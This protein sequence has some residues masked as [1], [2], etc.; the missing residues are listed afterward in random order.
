MYVGEIASAKLRGVFG[1]FPQLLL[2]LGSLVLYSLSAISGFHYHSIALVAVGIVA[3][4]ELGMVWLPETPRWLFSQ[5]MKD[6]GKQVLQ[7]LR[8]PKVSVSA[9]LSELEEAICAEKPSVSEVLREFTK[10]RLFFPFVLVLVIMFFQQISGMNAIGAYIVLLFQDAGISNPQLATVYVAII[11]FVSTL[12]SSYIVDVGGRKVL[13]TISGIGMAIGTAMLGVHFYITRPSLCSDHGEN[14]TL[15]ESLQDSS[16]TDTQCNKQYSPLAI[17]SVIVF[18]I[19]MALGW[20][21]V[22]WI[23]MA[24]LLPQKVRGLASGIATAVNWG[25]AVIVVGFYL[26]Y[27]KLVRLWFAWWSF[28]FLNL[29]GVVFVC[30]FVPETKRKTLEEIQARFEGGWRWGRAR[31]EDRRQ[32]LEVTSSMSKGGS[33]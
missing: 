11:G 33:D 27:A 8:G 29:V 9:E 10:W 32:S 24:E 18:A 30:A 17:V 20:G 21:P 1:T 5:G 16:D 2:S 3:V 19:A 31:Q 15:Y 23:L 12:P 14:S 13:L 22:P 25:T 7:W 28:A 4:F 26:D 6:E